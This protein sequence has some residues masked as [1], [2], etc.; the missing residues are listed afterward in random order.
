MRVRVEDFQSLQSVDFTATGL[1]VITGASNIGKTA[2]I[3]AIEGAL[4]GKPGDYYIK[5][6][7][8]TTKVRLQDKTLTSF[9]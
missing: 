8:H 4:F 5:H 3:R 2:L 1:T 6:G 9:G 7:E